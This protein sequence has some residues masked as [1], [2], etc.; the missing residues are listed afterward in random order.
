MEKLEKLY[1]SIKK[2]GRSPQQI[3]F[4]FYSKV[5]HTFF[6]QAFIIPLSQSYITVTRLHQEKIP[7]ATRKYYVAYGT[8][9]VSFK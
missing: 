3:R 9:P 5:G 8:V 4:N 6:Y 2:E 1:D 7:I